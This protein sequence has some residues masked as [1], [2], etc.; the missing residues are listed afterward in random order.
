MNYH[1]IYNSLVEQAK[2]SPFEGY[3]ES[4]HIIPK[5]MGG[6][7]DDSNLVLLSARQHYIAHLLLVKINPQ[8]HRLVYAANMMTVPTSK[9][10]ERTNNRRYEWIRE[11]LLEAERQ[12]VFSEETRR[13]MAEGKKNQKRVT[14]PHCQQ[15]GL[16][17]NMNRWHFDNCKLKPGNENIER[18]F[19][20]VGCSHKNGNVSKERATCPHCGTESTKNYLHSHIP[21]CA[22][23]PDR[24]T[25]KKR[26]Q[27]TCPHCQKTGDAS[28]IKRW[29]FNN[30]KFKPS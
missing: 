13:R 6:S 10:K 18:V 9:S 19:A 8:N 17:G 21:Y 27:L 28:N 3:K 1:K 2:T 30:C 12:K 29:H 15:E 7:D 20:G 25:P 23:N 24:K 4:H 11:R 5:C 22:K 16:I 26:E 14:C